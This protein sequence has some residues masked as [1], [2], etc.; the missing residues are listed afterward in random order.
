MHVKWSTYLF[1]NRHTNNDI[2]GRN[3]AVGM[4]SP[5]SSDEFRELA[6]Y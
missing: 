3:P 2:E 6:D 1:E 5:L 4:K